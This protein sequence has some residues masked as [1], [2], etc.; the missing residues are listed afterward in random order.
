MGRCKAWLP[1]GEKYLLRRVVDRIAGSVDSISVVAEQ[2]QD[3][4]PLP[5]SVEILRDDTSH[6]GPLLG[7]FTALSTATDTEEIIVLLA[8]DLPFVESDAI[9]ILID[10]VGA[11]DI[12][13]PEV[14]GRMQPLFAVYRRGVKAAVERLLKGGERRMHRLFDECD[15]L[16]VDEIELRGANANSNCFFNVNTMED[17]RRALEYDSLLRNPRQVETPPALQ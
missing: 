4:P 1:F 10:H 13:V 17:Y 6:E 12:A 14:E 8:G 2:S 3:L 9:R 5:D 15:T 11:H 7:L 16:V